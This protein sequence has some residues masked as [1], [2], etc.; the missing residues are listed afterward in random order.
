MG[1]LIDTCIWVDVERGALAPADV[2]S[3]TGDE[4]VFL[5]P[6]TIAELYFGAEIASEAGT[7]QKRLAV[8][9]RLQHK[10]VLKIDGETGLI[11]GRLATA[12]KTAGR[13]HRYRIQDLWLASQAIQYGY[14]FLTHNERDFKDIAGLDLVVMP[15]AGSVAAP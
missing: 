15:K 11:F 4:P 8:L 5:S 12:I 13:S 1:Y 9:Q 7:R 14:R 3:A 2:A 6:L 10:P